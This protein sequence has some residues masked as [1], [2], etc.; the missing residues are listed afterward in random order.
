MPPSAP[1]FRHPVFTRRA[2]IQAGAVGLLGLGAD[3]LAAL[4][5]AAAVPG[6]TPAR[7]AIYIFLSGGLSQLDSFDLKPDAPPEIRGEFRPAATRSPGV[8]ICEHLPRLAQRSH[9]WS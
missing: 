4:R 6:K 3:Q 1:L 8:R 5:A 2:A 9:L 7:A